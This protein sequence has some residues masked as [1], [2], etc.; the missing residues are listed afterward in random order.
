MTSQFNDRLILPCPRRRTLAV[1][2]LISIFALTNIASAQSNA[3]D[4]DSS[5]GTNVVDVNRAVSMV[6]GTMPCTAN[7]EAPNTCSIVT[8][9]RVVNAALGQS[10][11]SYGGGVSHSVGLAWLPSISVGLVGYN[12]YRSTTP[13]GSPTRLNSSP[14]T[15]TSF[16]DTSV[17]AGQTYYYSATST[18]GTGNESTFSTQVVA[19]IP[20]S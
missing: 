15:G 5:G 3:C 14:I 8:V 19:V 13:T 1:S 17:Q 9:Q 18:D 10:C 12:I 6:L 11:V 7:V 2:V 20:A 4:L 16:S